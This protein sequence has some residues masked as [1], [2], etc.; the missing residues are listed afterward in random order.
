MST[1][2]V[3]PDSTFKIYSGLF[4][5]EE[6]LISP[7]SSARSWDGTE[8]FFDSWNQDQ[9]LGDSHA[10]LCELVFPGAGRS[11]GIF[12]PLFYYSRI[13]YGNCDLSGGIGRYWAESSLKISPVEQTELLA[14]LL[15]NDGASAQRIYRQSGT[16]CLS[17]ILPPESFT[18]RPE[19][20]LTG[21]RN[22]N[23]WFIGFLEDKNQCVLLCS[24]HPGRSRCFRNHGFRDRNEYPERSS[25]NTKRNSFSSEVCSFFLTL[26]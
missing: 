13:S 3:S 16:R 19:P 1:K 21:N 6:G 26:L 25:L 11:D 24:K 12:H 15:Q 4:G 20:A 17:P 7:D 2:R 18:A 10:E 8:Y 22:I 23:G 14:D 9:T 5:L